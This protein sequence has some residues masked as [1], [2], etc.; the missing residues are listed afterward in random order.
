MQPETRFK[1]KVQKRLKKVPRSWWTKVQMVS[2]RGI[3]DILGCV[4]GHI[5]A[6]ELKVGDNS[7]EKDPLQKYILT[8]IKAVGGYARECRPE[9]L[10]EI[11][12]DIERKFSR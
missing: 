12:Q 10:E 4:G 1:E 3:P 9:N 2:I 11:A 5:I 7:I 8:K 6:L